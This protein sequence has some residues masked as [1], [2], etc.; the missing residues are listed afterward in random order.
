M[1]LEQIKEVKVIRCTGESCGRIFSEDDLEGLN[2][3]GFKCPDCHGKVIV[4]SK[5]DSEIVKDLEKAERLP[6]IEKA[7]LNIL[8]ELNSQKTYVVAKDIAEEVD[9]NSRRI[10]KICKKLDQEKGLVIRDTQVNPYKYAITEQ[11]RKYC[12]FR[13]S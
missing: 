5:V 11:G 1:I 8:I 12:V 13:E 7:E 3:T 9:M 10:A 4:E 6:L 2:F